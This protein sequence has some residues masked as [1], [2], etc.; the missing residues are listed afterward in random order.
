MEGNV[1]FFKLVVGIVTLMMLMGT[2]L[3]DPF[4]ICDPQTNVTHYVITLDGWSITVP[5][6]DLG[7]GTFNLRFDMG[8]I[9]VGN[10]N[11]EI[12][13]KNLWGESIGV[14]FGF[15]KSYTYKITWR[16]G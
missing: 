8:G 4:L 6:I 10:H 16:S 9:N 7:D 3:A 15:E 14:R 12:K 5:A 1:M 13:A 2:A 11:M